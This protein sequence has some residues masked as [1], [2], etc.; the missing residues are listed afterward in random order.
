MIKNERA[1]AP[2]GSNDTMKPWFDFINTWNYPALEGVRGYYSPSGKGEDVIGWWNIHP[3]WEKAGENWNRVLKGVSVKTGEMDEV[4]ESFFKQMSALHNL[5]DEWSDSWIQLCRTAYEFGAESRINDDLNVDQF[6]ETLNSVMPRLELALEEYLKDSPFSELAPVLPAVKKSME[7][8]SEEKKVATAVWKEWIT[9]QRK[10]A[11]LCKTAVDEWVSALENVREGGQP[12]TT[13]V[14]QILVEYGLLIKEITKKLNI[15]HEI[16]TH[17]ETL[18]DDRIHMNN[19]GLDSILSWTEMTVKFNRALFE[20]TRELFSFSN[21]YKLLA[22]GNLFQEGRN[23]YDT[24]IRETIRNSEISDGMSEWM[25]ATA[26]F[27]KSCQAFSMNCLMPFC[28]PV[29]RPKQ[30]KQTEASD[31][32]PYADKTPAMENFDQIQ[33][34]KKY[35][36]SFR[37]SNT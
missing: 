35:A 1:E 14:R 37:Q 30:P 20:S 18:M 21:G 7:A 2:T 24:F 31:K 9:T 12:P 15:P 10:I 29:S 23:Q 19:K 33:A 11:K 25:T 16:K 3:D 36:D 8:F 13:T 26:E 5:Q 27:T 32:M 28:L 34:D 22:E 17:I 6:A 4:S